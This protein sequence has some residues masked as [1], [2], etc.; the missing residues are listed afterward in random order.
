MDT[1]YPNVK[2]V[3]HVGKLTVEILAYRHLTK[4]ECAAAIRNYLL[5]TRR[6]SL[7]TKGLIQIVTIIGIDS[8]IDL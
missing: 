6:K 2:T 5:K 7:P 1:L 4:D 3:V 8:S